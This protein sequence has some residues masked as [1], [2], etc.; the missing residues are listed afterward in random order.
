[1]SLSDI[2]PAARPQAGAR[3]PGDPL[4]WPTLARL[5]AVPRSLWR[6]RLWAAARRAGAVAFSL[7]LALLAIFAFVSAA[8]PY[9]ALWLRLAAASWL[10][11]LWPLALSLVALIRVVRAGHA[12]RIRKGKG[13]GKGAGAAEVTAVAGE[14]DL[15]N[16]AAP[17][18]FRTALRPEAH[19]PA[20]RDA[21]EV[22]YA[23]WEPRLR[24]PPPPRVF[25]PDRAGRARR[26]LAGATLA[27]VMAIL[28][29]PFWLSRSVNLLTGGPG[30]LVTR[31]VFP[32]R[33]LA[34]IPSPRL[35]PQ[36][37][38]AFIAQGD[39]LVVTVAVEHV[40]SHSPVYARIRV[41]GAG[42]E[43]EVR[44]VLSPAPSVAG[45]AAASGRHSAHD[46]AHAPHPDIAPVERQETRR[47][48]RNRGV[49]W[50]TLRFGPVTRD[51]SV[52]FTVRQ[53]ATP[54][55]VVTV[56]APPRLE[57]LSAVVTPPAYTRLP[58][59]TYDLFPDDFAVLPGTHIAWRGTV[60]RPLEAWVAHWTP[61]ES[62]ASAGT[63]VPGDAGQVRQVRQVHEEGGAAEPSPQFLAGGRGQRVGAEH[64]VSAAGALHLS[65]SDHA[66]RG[67][68]R[69]DAGPWRIALR[70]D[71]PPEIAL[72]TPAGDGEWPRSLKVPIVFRATD[73]FGVTTVRLHYTVR[74][75]Q[76]AVKASGAR[77]VSTWRDGRDGRGA[78]VWDIA[79]PAEAAAPAL[80]VAGESVELFLEALDN[81][82]VAGPSRARS[83]TVRLHLPSLEEAREVLGERE[84]AA[85]TGLTSALE[86]EKRRE[87]E[88]ARPDRAAAAEGMPLAAEWDVRR[89]L[90]DAPR[91]HAQ[92]MRR[93]I[94]AEL[95]MARTL[96][97]DADAGGDPQEAGGRPRAP[98]PQPSPHRQDAEKSVSALEALHRKVEELE[99]RIPEPSA[100][101]ASL[102]EQ[103][104]L[105]GAL[106]EDQRQLER[107]LA[108]TR[109]PA[110]GQS[111]SE[112]PS[113]GEAAE[114]S[115]HA[116]AQKPA[117]QAARE[118]AMRENRLRLEAELKANRQDQE[119]LQGWL[120]D[121]QRAQAAEQARR[122]AA[123]RQAG[124]ARDDLESALKQMEQAMRAGIEDGTLTPDLLEKMDRVRELLEEVLEE[125]EMEAWR[126]SAFGDAPAPEELRRAMEDM[127]R[128]GGMRQE[129][130][131]AIRM[132]EAVRDQR[133]LQSLA[134]D[135]RTL[136][137]GQRE[138]AR[139]LA[140][141]AER[142]E[143]GMRPDDERAEAE[144][145]ADRQDEL[146]RRMERSLQS[147]D[148]LA[149]KPSMKALRKESLRAS[150]REALQ[151]MERTRD[152]LKRD[153]PDRRR[154]QESANLAAEKTAAAAADMEKALAQMS[155]GDDKAEMRAVLEETLEFT[156]WLEAVNGSVG[157]LHE[158]GSGTP[159]PSWNVARSREDAQSV[160]RVAHWLSGRMQALAEARAFESDVL[161]RSAAAMVVHADALATDGSSV[162][163]AEV[164]RHARSG[165]RELLKWLSQPEGSG[166]SDEG[167]GQ[168]DNDFGGGDQGDGEEGSQG[169]A[170]RMRGASGQQM[171]ANRMT[172][173]L[174][175]SLMEERRLEQG[176]GEGAPDPRG[177]SP[178]HQAS[179]GRGQ[180]DGQNGEPGGSAYD[181]AGGA[182]GQG[183]GNPGNPGRGAGDPPGGAGDPAGM[184]GAS[185]AMGGSGRGEGS[186]RE[187]HARGAAAHAQQQVADALESMAERADDAGGA[188]RT[189]RRLAEEARELE[190][191][192][193]DG[194]LA[195]EDIRKRQE[196]FRTRLLQ[197]AE[198]MEERGQ[199]QER[200][201]E[202]W[203]GGME[204][205]A[206]A[207][208]LPADSLS[209]ELKRRREQARRLPLT[210][211]QKR[212]VEWYYERL[213]GE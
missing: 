117:E 193:R 71:R 27:L 42:A 78:G 118:R 149:E 114:P 155:R 82:A 175:R 92:A 102:E 18:V 13:V 94:A 197:S 69:G 191:A 202:I 169:M 3:A 138:V 199:R 63:G 135:M 120:H 81:N 29:A 24:V 173:E 203:R 90:S 182:N 111:R 131:Q 23:Q 85:A 72:L 127:K 122:E 210:P 110:P 93:Q 52:R 133:A 144:V 212:R 136:E 174:L 178:R 55:H 156:R 105:L 37:L 113:R 95:G 26:L 96:A 97:R 7:Q 171:A 162:A 213:L 204:P 134:A 137:E 49:T 40:P 36:D 121:R 143:A 88:A 200:R 21:L 206:G 12:A 17:D 150:A 46:S 25:G 109:P 65:L 123:A 146:A 132:L 188:A 201:G 75:A 79:E 58:R 158:A 129:L 53:T 60:D 89:V 211:E 125:Q 145:F 186:G 196:Q 76:G 148:R 142:A 180:R 91:H 38:P 115:A 98:H 32:G 140:D 101:Q 139:E 5:G 163:L 39:S 62:G 152:Q 165:A 80:P 100:A 181:P 8:R 119:Q 194:R 176:G 184:G 185:G 14:L 54:P 161:R 106:R 205:V 48:S 141:A 11:W 10:L 30:D 31:M 74:D 66:A 35:T 83:A 44:Y 84:R 77:D 159:G 50:R 64:R 2:D 45:P 190:R 126:Q 198:A 33:V 177:G 179:T 6:A 189:L 41:A 16:P 124:Q 20:T 70:P 112:E 168:G 9:D 128:P 67:G 108:D 86:R 187:G 130:E 47:D 209:A 167:D 107:A 153:R 4:R 195:P 160:A 59:E 151:Q 19:A 172:Q 170:S 104:A 166:G 99:R 28:A 192:L 61:Q 22:L 164:R 73:D 68:A 103:Q 57:S 147:M 15:L 157:S 183:S 87:R 207:V 56:V 1:M 208:P 43:E 116:S 51:V 34:A 154:G